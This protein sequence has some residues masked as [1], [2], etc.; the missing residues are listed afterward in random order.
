MILQGECS[1]IFKFWLE[2]SAGVQIA[3]WSEIDQPLTHFSFF[4]S[5][6][7]QLLP[8]KIAADLHDES[9]EFC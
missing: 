1:E 4:D 3:Y 7:S 8:D 5:L 6:S 9:S 2:Y